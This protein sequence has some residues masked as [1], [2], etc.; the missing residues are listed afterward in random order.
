MKTLA[1]R[2][3]GPVLLSVPN[4]KDN[5]Q[6][7]CLGGMNPNHC[8]TIELYRLGRRQSEM[9]SDSKPLLSQAMAANPCRV[10]NLRVWS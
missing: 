2:P 9:V 1:A 7:K 4:T 5:Q 3:V 10:G 8:S 6:T